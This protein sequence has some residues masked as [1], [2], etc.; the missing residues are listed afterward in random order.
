MNKRISGAIDG[1]LAY[2]A[3]R[4][5]E[6]TRL[7][8]RLIAAPSENLPGDETA[9]A[10]VMREAIA[11]LGLPPAAEFARGRKLDVEDVVGGDGA[12]VAA[13]GGGG[14]GGVEDLFERHGGAPCG[15]VDGADGCRPW[16][17]LCA[18]PAYDT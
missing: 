14:F 2:L 11:A 7:T 10:E 17:V 6:A 12:A 5:G 15:W 13:A 18:C 16:G 3:P 4:A 8:M 9:P 1:A